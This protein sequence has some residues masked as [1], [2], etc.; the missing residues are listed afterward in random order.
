MN[1]YAD[2][3]NPPD[4]GSHSFTTIICEHCGHQIS[5]PVYC[6]N[7]FCPICSRPRLARVRRRIEFMVKHTEKRNGY[8]FKHLTLTVRSKN[9]LPGMLRSLSA[10]FR[11]LRQRPLWKRSVSGGAFVFEVTHKEGAFHAHIHSIIYSKF[12]DW[13]ALLLLWMSVSDGRG[14]YIQRIP[15]HQIVRYLT[16]YISKPS[17]NPSIACDVQDSLSHFRLFSPFGTW[18]N[19]SKDFVD[20]KPGCPKCG[21]RALIPIDIFYSYNRSAVNLAHAP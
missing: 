12:I 13:N 18:Y 17:S 2:P 15:E 3:P 21:S 8:S 16:K 1:L 19:I 20:E 4:D 10:S 14:V 9:D 6:G 5:V 7:R 11:R